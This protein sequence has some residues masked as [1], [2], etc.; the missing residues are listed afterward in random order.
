MTIDL[1]PILG[2]PYKEVVDTTI[3][4]DAVGTVIQ[5]VQVTRSVKNMEFAANG[6][7]FVLVLIVFA[8]ILL[9]TVFPKKRG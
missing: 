7:I 6:F 9:R 1:K 3:T 5:Q 2:E 4:M 8:N